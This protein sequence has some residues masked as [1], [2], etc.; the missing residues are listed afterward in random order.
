MRKDYKIAGG[1]LIPC[2]PD[3]ADIIDF[4]NPDQAEMRW[5]IDGCSISDHNILSALDPDE[6]GR[7]EF[8]EDHL[9]IILK[10]PKNYCSADNFMFKVISLGIFLYADRLVIISARGES[11]IEEVPANHRVDSLHDALVLLLAS[12]ISHFL[13]HLKVINML[14]DALEDKV[15]H[16]MSNEHLIN[17]FTISKSLVYYLNG[18]NSNQ[19]VMEKAK[20]NAKRIGFND[21]QLEHLDDVIIDNAQCNKQAEIYST[22]LTGL[23]DSRG[24]I[25]NNNMSMLIKRLTIVSIVF[26]PL[27]VLAGM[28]G[29]SEFSAMTDGVPKVIS[30]TLFGIGLIGVAWLTYIIVRRFSGDEAKPVARRHRLPLLHG[31]RE[32]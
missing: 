21:T 11:A 10:I 23:M 12:T 15:R 31:R 4:S 20:L 32:K 14:T 18:I 27:N 3:E 30:Y 28:G 9:A 24:S 2:E 19:V 16:S 13:G 1:D 8:E 29:M 7:I 5:L 26:M 25:V 22:I 17:M 6:Q